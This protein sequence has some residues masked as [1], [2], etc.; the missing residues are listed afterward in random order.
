[1]KRKFV[2]RAIWLILL[3]AVS[4]GVWFVWPRLP[5]ITAFA[6]KGMCSSVFLAEKEPDR[7]Q[8]E[9]LSF[10]PISLAKTKVNYEEKTATSTVFGLA[11]RKAVFRE[12]AGAVI[13]L[14]TDVNVLKKTGFQLPEPGFLQDTIPWPK[15][16]II[17][18]TLPSG[19]NLPRLYELIDT[20]FD[21]PGS[22]P[23]KKTLG[24]AVIYK[25]QL[26]AEKYLDG[27]DFNTKASEIL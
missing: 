1:M 16:N 7:V 11:R 15:G 20:C 3:I 23:F 17:A 13:V 5:I 22:E 25:N 27:Y 2:K 24:V 8:A 14:K 19:V 26:I 18:D 10:F 21:T 4:A 12:G 9:D 6:A